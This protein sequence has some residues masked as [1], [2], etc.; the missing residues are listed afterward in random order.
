MMRCWISLIST[1]AVAYFLHNGTGLALFWALD[2]RYQS[3]PPYFETYKLDIGRIM[4]SFEVV[5]H[6]S[7]N[8]FSISTLVDG[9]LSERG[10]VYQYGDTFYHFKHLDSFI[11]EKHCYT[12]LNYSF[13]F[14][15]SS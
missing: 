12:T 9:E 10:E 2:R 3:M 7:I 1:T 13:T 8:K 14:K 5:A 11:G 4:Y 15:L 6:N